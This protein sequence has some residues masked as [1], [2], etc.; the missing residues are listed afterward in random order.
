MTNLRAL[1]LGTRVNFFAVLDNFGGRLLTFSYSPTVGEVELEFMHR[2]QEIRQL[3]LMSPMAPNIQHPGNSFMPSLE[4]IEVFLGDVLR[5]I[6]FGH[7]KHEKIQYRQRDYKWMPIIPLTFTR[8]STVGLTRLEVQPFQLELDNPAELE[9]LLPQLPRSTLTQDSSWGTEDLP[10][11]DF[12]REVP[13]NLVRH[14]N[15]LPKLRY[16]HVLSTYGIPQARQLH[17]EIPGCCTASRFDLFIFHGKDG[18]MMWPDVRDDDEEDYVLT[19]S[20]FCGM[21][22]TIRPIVSLK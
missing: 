1:H 8:L 4:A 12:V 16:L 13:L 21:H 15:H 20:G 19:T 5:L 14:L 10:R 6:G 11:P 9:V 18:C 17:H 22:T 2:Q 3:T 7:V